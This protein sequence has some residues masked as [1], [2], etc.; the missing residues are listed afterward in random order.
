MSISAAAPPVFVNTLSSEWQ[1][2]SHLAI[3][4]IEVSSDLMSKG[5]GNE[6]QAMSMLDATYRLI[7]T[8]SNEAR[9]VAL[10]HLLHFGSQQNTAACVQQ[11]EEAPDMYQEDECDVGPRALQAPVRVAAMNYLSSDLALLEMF[12]VFNKTLIHHST[13]SHEEAK[14]LYQHIVSTVQ[15]ALQLMINV[16]SKKLLE[17]GM[18]AHNNLGQIHY[19]EGDEEMACVHFEA[20]ILFARQLSDLSRS[21]R[22]EYA[23]VLSNWCR[24]NTMRGDISDNLYSGLKEVL[25]L[26]ASSLQW[27][28]V[29]VAAA[30]YNVGVAEYARQRSQKANSHLLQ[31]LQVAHSRNKAQEAPIL[32]SIPAMIHLL[33]IQNEDKD[34]S[35]S[36]ELVRG[37]RTLQDKRQDQGPHSSDVAS[38]L[39]FIGTLLFHKE[40]Y[41]NAL[42]FFREELRLEED[43]AQHDETI[44]VS[45]TCNNI[46]RILQELGRSHEA[47][48]YYQQALK[49]EYGDISQGSVVKGATLCSIAKTGIT[50]NSPATSN[51]YS[52]VWYNLGLIHDK[53]GAYGDAISAFKMSLE[54]RRAMLGRDHPDV[55]CLLYNIGVLQMEQQQLNE[56]TFSFRE[57]L[58]IRRVA[59]TGQLNDHHVVKTLEKLASLHKAKGN[60]EGALEA[61][62]QV[63]HIQEASSD[64]DPIA[65]MKEMG[66]MLRSIAELHHAIGDM[67]AGITT[68]ME[69]VCKL[70]AVVDMHHAKGLL[71]QCV[72]KSTDVEQLVSSLLLVGSIHHENADPLKAHSTFQ[73]AVV[74]LQQNTGGYQTAPSSLDALLEVTLMLA[75]AQC[76][77]EA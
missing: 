1:I 77:P 47:I 28:H 45:V 21:Y 30:H 46:G 57:A 50:D 48:Y 56:A 29:D 70:Q 8:P 27:D 5:K 58:R 10:S 39:N 23:N 69:S 14:Q 36:L 38:V 24:V 40:D 9:S 43:L 13:G 25:R 59:S 32:D 12:V 7:H 11:D 67:D 63:L 18:R 15:N 65:R 33:L 53:L 73:E 42:L 20:S 26:R 52:T 71:A 4:L 68:A 19:L 35:M 22:L 60:I 2:V 34:D 75:T 55:A 66:V 6:E 62:R 54:L 51:L 17:V 64:Y 76:A 3:S 44:S 37:L 72:E 74:I 49:S 61:S 31:Y 16:P 41:E